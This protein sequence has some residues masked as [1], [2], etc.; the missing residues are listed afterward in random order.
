MPQ[1]Q[2]EASISPWFVGRF[3]GSMEKYV[4]QSSGGLFRLQDEYVS[5]WT[6]YRSPRRKM[7]GDGVIKF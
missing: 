6:S 4:M 2:M 1:R 5:T 3:E 7:L